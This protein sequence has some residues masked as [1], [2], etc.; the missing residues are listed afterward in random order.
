MESGL[1]GATLFNLG[2]NL[3][4]TVLALV[5][6]NYME[7]DYVVGNP[8]YVRVQHLPDRQ[9]MM[10]DRRMWSFVVLSQI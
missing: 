6:K 10:F 3:L 7:Y 1:L 4:C 8:P 9:K 2:V 5:V